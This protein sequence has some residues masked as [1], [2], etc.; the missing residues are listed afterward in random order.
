[1]TG[2][3]ARSIMIDPLVVHTKS[4]PKIQMPTQIHAILLTRS[5]VKHGWACRAFCVPNWA[6]NGTPHVRPKNGQG[7]SCGTAV[8]T[9]NGEHQ[10]ECHG[11]HTRQDGTPIHPLSPY[12]PH[13]HTLPSSPHSPHAHAPTCSVP[14]ECSG[15]CAQWKVPRNGISININLSFLSTQEPP[16]T[17]L[18]VD[19][20]S[21]HL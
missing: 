1:V 18:E 3:S 11:Q 21:F 4:A 16:K 10:G 12:S 7:S 2:V 5:G 15:N 17:R 9:A 19:K 6:R 14:P 8:T 20:V 13:E